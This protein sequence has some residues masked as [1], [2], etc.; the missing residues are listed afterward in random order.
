MHSAFTSQPHIAAVMTERVWLTARTLRR[1]A[2]D[3]S[4]GWQDSGGKSGRAL[5]EETIDWL[6]TTRF[7]S[8]NYPTRT[9][10]EDDRLVQW[11]H[12]KPHARTHARSVITVSSQRVDQAHRQSVCSCTEPTRCTTRRS[13]SA[14]G[15]L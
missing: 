5:V 10:G 7:P 8:G 13:I 4:A 15:Q 12:G 6:I 11:C 2:H 9:D 14:V 1:P 3:C